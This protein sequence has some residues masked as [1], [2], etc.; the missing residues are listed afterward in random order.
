MKKRT[1]GQKLGVV[2]GA[3]LALCVLLVVVSAVALSS[4]T[5][6]KDRVIDVN[7]RLLAEAASLQNQNERYVSNVRAFVIAPEPHF[8]DVLAEMSAAFAATTSTLTA[9]SLDGAAAKQV[10][11]IVR[12][13]ADQRAVA[14]DIVA[15]RKAGAPQATLAGMLGERFEAQR[16]PLR[17]AIDA[18]VTSETQRLKQAQSASTETAVQGTR[19]I[20]GCA[21]LTILLTV[22][23]LFVFVGAM[24]RQVSGAVQSI[25]GSSTQLQAAASQQAGA[26]QQLGAVTVEVSTTLKELF[27][28]S[29]Q[30]AERAQQ[31]AG[32]S[33]K[34]ALASR[35]SQGSVRQAEQGMAGIQ[36]QVAG[37]VSHIADLAA[38]TEKI[39]QVA[40]IISEFADQTDILATNAT[41]EAVNAGVAG[42]RFGVVAGEVRK[43]AVNVSE[44]ARSID[45]LVAEVTTAA[46]TSSDATRE[47]SR[48]VVEGSGQVGALA[49]RFEL[50]SN[51][52]SSSS[53]AA[54]EI[55]LSTKQQASAMEQVANALSDVAQSARQTQTTSAQTLEASVQLTA[56]A[57][58]LSQLVQVGAH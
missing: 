3:L 45:V 49:S 48:V 5:K 24:N 23:L 55:E 17:K 29:R 41:I 9:E 13:Y 52:V 39:G 18:F 26:S 7:A 40:A 30:I 28:S 21:A 35:E 51:L 12:A 57:G 38:K 8:L 11:E 2:F 46:R 6:S 27:S 47:A 10:A 4:V 33:H 44:A 16:T 36:K 22:P 50:I 25:S 15:Q 32:I 31:V 58:E 43:L 42:A 37:V 56:L 20:V 53:E 19:L 1:V 14:E 54:R 34:A